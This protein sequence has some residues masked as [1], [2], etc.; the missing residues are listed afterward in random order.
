MHLQNNSLDDFFPL[1]K[2]FLFSFFSFFFFSLLLSFFLFL[3]YNSVLVLLSHIN[4][5]CHEVHVFPVPNS[6]PTSLPTIPPIFKWK[7]LLSNLFQ[8]IITQA[9]SRRSS[10]DRLFSIQ[11]YL[12]FS[13]CRICHNLPHHCYVPTSCLENSKSADY[14]NYKIQVAHKLLKTHKI[15]PWKGQWKYWSSIIN[16]L[17]SVSLMGRRLVLHH[18]LNTSLTTVYTECLFFFS[19]PPNFITLRAAS[20]CF[21]P[22]ATSKSV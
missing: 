7:N 13:N 9:F 5:I 16:C 1:D 18:E 2:L 11:R 3:L 10:A 22:S 12:Y 4:R 19:S 21:S 17:Y 6:P 20:S 15:C 8:Q 14:K